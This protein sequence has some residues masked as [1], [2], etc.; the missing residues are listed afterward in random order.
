[1]IR[2]GTTKYLAPIVLSPDELDAWADAHDVG[3]SEVT[4]GHFYAVHADVAS[5]R[6]EVRMAYGRAGVTV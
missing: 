1:M 2:V 3:V 6:V 4:P 5:G